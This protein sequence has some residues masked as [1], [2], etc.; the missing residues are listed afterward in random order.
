MRDEILEI[1]ARECDLDT[2]PA[3][4]A[5]LTDLDTDSV[6]VICAI[7]A[8]E[9]RFE[10]EIPFDGNTTGVETVGDIVTMVEKLIVGESRG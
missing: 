5:S 4:S 3:L 1:L 6:D 2:I 9:D 8:L 10:I 7:N